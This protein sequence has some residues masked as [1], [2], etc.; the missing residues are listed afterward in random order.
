VSS[1]DLLK[2]TFVPTTS[3]HKG[4]LSPPE[5][6][7]KHV[8]EWYKTMSKFEESNSEKQLYPVNFIGTDGAAVATKQCPPFLDAMTAGYHYVLEGDLT[9]DIGD[10]GK[11][12]VSWTSDAMI[13]DHRPTLELPVP[14]GH[15]PI[16]YGFKMGWY[17][18]TPPGYSV[19]ITHPMNRYDLPFT[20]QSGIVESDIWGLPVFVAFFL[21]RG[22]R[23]TIPKGTP[24]FQIIPFKR[25]NWEMEVDDSEETIQRHV[26]DAEKRRTR[27]HGYYKWFAWRKKIFR[28]MDK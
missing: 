7:Y 19:L 8:P 15:H 17:Y 26:F 23:G 28:G 24:I 16:H 1:E 20:V 4:L 9:V 10:D 6:A 27:I 5:P 18:E 14:D 13:V 21:K 12:I 22:F 25:D 2:I 11:P 3:R